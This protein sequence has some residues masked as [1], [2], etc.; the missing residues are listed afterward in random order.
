MNMQ[1]QHEMSHK[2]ACKLRHFQENQQV[3]RQNGAKFV[4]FERSDEI[5]ES[6]ISMCNFCFFI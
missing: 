4:A 2:F 6:I 5:H 3:L 1:L